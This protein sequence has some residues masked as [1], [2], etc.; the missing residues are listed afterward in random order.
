[1]KSVTIICSYSLSK[2]IKPSSL[3]IANS[4]FFRIFFQFFNG[5]LAYTIGVGCIFIVTCKLYTVDRCYHSL[6]SRLSG[7]GRRSQVHAPSALIR[8]RLFEVREWLF[9]ALRFARAFNKRP[10]Y[11]AMPL[12]GLSGHFASLVVSK[13]SFAWPL[14]GLSGHVA[15]LVVSKQSFATPRDGLSGHFALLVISKKVPATNGDFHFFFSKTPDFDR[16]PIR[17]LNQN[18]HFFET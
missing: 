12:R 2:N 10:P 14:H 13:K 17:N 15:S 6:R 8:E 16:L 3:L 4:A 11:F 9:G 1:M 5:F 18:S 7:E